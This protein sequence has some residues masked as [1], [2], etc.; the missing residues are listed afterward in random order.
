L[1]RFPDG[2]DKPGFFQK[3]NSRYYPEWI[4]TATL[5]KQ[6]GTVRHVVCEDAA[7]LMY[8][9][10]QAAIVLHTW[11]SRVD[12][13]DHPDQMIFDFDPSSA[14]DFRNV[15]RAAKKLRELLKSEGL[16]AYVKTTGSRGLHVLV[17][18]NRRSDF[19]TVRAYAREIAEALAETDPK[20][21]TTDIRKAKR[22]GRIFIDVARNAYAQTAVPA[23]AVRARDGAPV[24]A[25]LDWKELDNPRLRPD[26]FTIRN[27]FSRLKRKGDPWQNV[28]RR[29]QKLP[30]R[31]ER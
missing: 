26:Q 27:I 6:D 7:T 30:R 15:C 18:L 12:K 23:Y 9:A 29:T 8:L 31:G 1:Q 2:I 25:P 24:A 4:R 28:M 5:K 22:R 17:P 13:P 14:G 20:Q 16:T 10:N 19:D 21:L 11:L 3:K